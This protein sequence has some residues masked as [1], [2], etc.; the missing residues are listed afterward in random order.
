[1]D[2]EETE[3]SPG[4]KESSEKLTQKQVKFIDDAFDR[5]LPVR[6]YGGYAEEALLEGRVTRGHHDVD[7]V[8]L[9][10]DGDDIRLGFENLG[11]NVSE[12]TEDGAD[13]PYKFLVK[14]GGVEADI[15]FL[16]WDEDRNQP[17]AETATPEGKKVRAYFDRGALAQGTQQLDGMGVQTVSPLMQM[18]MREAFWLVKRGEPRQQDLDKQEALRQKFFPAEGA[19]SG[20]FKPEIVEVVNEGSPLSS[21]ST[22][23]LREG[24]N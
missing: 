3:M 14:R 23:E 7:M 22:A 4:Q 9:R 20:K 19:G 1:M 17:Y 6:L 16:D 13:K 11:C 2:G 10:K 8:A 12:H 5:D 18:Q 15:A 21:F 24:T